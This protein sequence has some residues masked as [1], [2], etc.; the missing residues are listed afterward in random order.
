MSKSSTWLLEYKR[1]VYSQAGE[2]GIIEKIIEVIPRSDKWCVEFGAWD[3]LFLSNTRHLI[4][5][6]GFSSILIEADKEK[7]NDLQ[8]N[9]SQYDNVFTI[10]EFVGFG[11]DD[12]LDR[13]LDTTPVPSELD[14]LSIDI[15][16]NDYHVWK[17]VSK[18][19]PKVVIIEFN[20]TIPTH[21]RFVQ[22]ADPS[23]TQ[24]ASLLSL[25]ELGKEKGY[26]LVSALHCNALFVRE[27]YYPLF[28]IESN[29]PEVLRTDLGAITYFFSGYDG[30]IFLSGNSRMPWHD[31][32]ILKE[33]KM[34]YLPRFLRKYPENYTLA[35]KIAFRIYKRLHA[36]PSGK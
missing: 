19:R 14:L 9:Y 27:E 7:F 26:E 20:P 2:D 30:R 22:P 25:V 17:A 13:I 21:I 4:E 10:N 12:N 23:I 29:A 35:Q 8:R 16:G 32:I 6:K 15:D 11:E 36:K 18:Y 34:Q 31:G 5:A 24:G 33:S 28:Q 3:G 1:D